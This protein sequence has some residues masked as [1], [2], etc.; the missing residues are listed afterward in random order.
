MK[1]ALVSQHSNSS[2]K[3]FPLKSSV[4]EKR[5]HISFIYSNM[6]ETCGAS[7]GLA[8][9]ANS[10]PRKLMLKGV[11]LG[12]DQLFLRPQKLLKNHCLLTEHPR[13]WMSV[14]FPFTP[15]ILRSSQSMNCPYNDVIM[16]AL[17]KH[18]QLVLTKIGQNHSTVKCF[19]AF[20]ESVLDSLYQPDVNFIHCSQLTWG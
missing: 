13:P 19:P 5:L 12:D 10:S 16:N 11:G 18:C 17:M 4:Q 7:M 14:V 9:V 20:P 2:C 1:E 6:L 8:D 3:H 15:G